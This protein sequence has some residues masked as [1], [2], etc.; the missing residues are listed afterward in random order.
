MEPIIHYTQLQ[1]LQ[2]HISH[3]MYLTGV[4]TENETWWLTIRKPIVWRHLLTDLASF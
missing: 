4:E 3:I 2:N 1:S